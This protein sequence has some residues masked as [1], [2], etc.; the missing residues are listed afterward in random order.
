MFAKKNQAF[1]LVL[2]PLINCQTLQDM[3]PVVGTLIVT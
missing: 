1:S 3:L 2:I